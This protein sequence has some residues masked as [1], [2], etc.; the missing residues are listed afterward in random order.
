MRYVCVFRPH[1]FIYLPSFPFDIIPNSQHVGA[2]NFVWANRY[3]FL[4]NGRKGEVSAWSTFTRALF[5]MM[6]NILIKLSN[7]FLKWGRSYYHWRC[8]LNFLQNTPLNS[9]FDI[10]LQKLQN[11][12]SERL[13]NL[14]T[15]HQRYPT[16]T[17]KM[18]G[19]TCN[20]NNTKSIMSG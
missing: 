16:G 15:T 11:F 20:K 5:E 6:N 19:H 8:Q 18:M 9:T 10:S 4:L 17:E 1:S 7:K 13:I 3:R 12:T 2:A 14:L